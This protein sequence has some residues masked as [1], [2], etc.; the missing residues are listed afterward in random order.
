MKELATFIEID[1]KPDI[2]WPHVVAFHKYSEWNPFITKVQGNAVVGEKV[3]MTMLLRTPDGLNAANHTIGPRIVKVEDEHEIRW[4]HGALF[5]W[6]L[7]IEHWCRITQRKGGIK[8]HQCLRVEGLLT[9]VMKDD[10]FAM[11]RQGFMDM[12]AALKKRTESL[13]PAKEPPAH[14]NAPIA[15]D[16]AGRQVLSP[17]AVR[18]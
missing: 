14:G 4:E 1:V 16:N 3:N 10:Y 15:N 18:A 12:N 17:D 6:L 8:F 2:V 9:T 5:S 7:N 13:A 11:F